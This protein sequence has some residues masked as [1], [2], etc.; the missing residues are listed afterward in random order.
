MNIKYEVASEAYSFIKGEWKL[1]GTP[2]QVAMYNTYE[3][4]VRACGPFE[5]EL[6]KTKENLIEVHTLYELQLDANDDVTNAVEIGYK[7]K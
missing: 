4:A 6:P 5:I 2:Q 1:F 3:E 7:T